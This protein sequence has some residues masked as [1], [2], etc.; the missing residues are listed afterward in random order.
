MKAVVVLPTKNEEE[1]IEYMVNKIRNLK[2]P[3]FVVDEHSTDKTLSIAKKLKVEV[4]QRDGSGKGYG[5]RKAIEIALKKGYDIIILIDC[6]RTYPSEYIPTL[7]KY[8]PKYDMVVGARGMGHV[9]PLHRL[10]N[11][12]HT[13]SINLLYGANLK[14]INSGLRAFKVNKLKGLDAGG[15]DIEAQITTKALKR[16]LRIKEL[17]IEYKKRTGESKIRIK[18]G[19]DILSR[20]FIER[21]RR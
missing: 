21:F 11:I 3:L 15:F 20:I 7:L 19:F 2:L 1:N 13:E 12:V 18:D 9:R 6:D 8:F 5:V 10:P 17:P 16:R 14:D 4:Y